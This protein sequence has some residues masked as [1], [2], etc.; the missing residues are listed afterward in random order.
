MMMP[1][2]GHALD[3]TPS[4]S[5]LHGCFRLSTTTTESEGKREE[6]QTQRVEGPLWQ[7]AAT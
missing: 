6:S 5:H 2:T 1:M 7:S 4:T 3:I